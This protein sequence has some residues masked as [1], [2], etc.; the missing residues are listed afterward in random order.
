MIAELIGPVTT[1]ETILFLSAV[2]WILYSYP[3]LIAGAFK[4]VETHKQIDGWAK[5]SRP[6]RELIDG[7]IEHNENNRRQERQSLH[8]LMMNLKEQIAEIGEAMDELRGIATNVKEMVV[9]L[10]ERQT[11]LSQRQDRLELACAN[12]CKSVMINGSSHNQSSK[13]AS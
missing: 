12:A 13:H 2:A 10:E 7:R 5:E 11:A 4:N 6:L 3:R 9:I 8:D 1:R